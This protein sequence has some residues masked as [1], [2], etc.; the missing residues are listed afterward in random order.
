MDTVILCANMYIETKKVLEVQGSH[1]VNQDYFQVQIPEIGER[2][3]IWL[4]RPAG[5][6]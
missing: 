3:I 2:W 6:I 4:W 1:A 5:L